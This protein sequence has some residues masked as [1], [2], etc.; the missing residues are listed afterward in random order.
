MKWNIKCAKVYL[1][2]AT[3][4]KHLVNN[5]VTEKRVL[6][7]QKYIGLTDPTGVTL[8]PFHPLHIG[9]IPQSLV[10]GNPHRIEDFQ[11][12]ASSSYGSS[13]D[14]GPSSSRLNGK[15]QAGVNKGAWCAQNPYD[16]GNEWL[17]VGY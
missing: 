11:L 1:H 17:Q 16:T 8:I 10:S 4:L 15:Y 5:K 14:Y 3:F 13:S 6:C 2:E 7:L 9:C 12:T